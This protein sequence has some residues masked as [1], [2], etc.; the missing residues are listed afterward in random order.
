MWLNS[1]NYSQVERKRFNEAVQVY[2]RTIRSIPQNIIANIM[3]LTQ[4][5]YFEAAQNAQEAPK[6][7]F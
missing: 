7:E 2:N 6:V 3:G 4:R 1:N 5:G